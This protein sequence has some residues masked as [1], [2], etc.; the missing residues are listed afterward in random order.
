L[1]SLSVAL[2]KNIYIS[3]F[4]FYSERASV[5]F[6]VAVPDQQ[7]PALF[8]EHCHTL[9]LPGAF[10]SLY[11]VLMEDKDFPR[12]PHCMTHGI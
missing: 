3:T 11:T 9:A 1:N 12:I 10:G 8:P 5:L 2:D 6:L 7:L 4:D